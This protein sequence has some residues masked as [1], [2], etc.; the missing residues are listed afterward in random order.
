[1]THS[2]MQQSVPSPATPDLKRPPDP[3]GADRGRLLIVDDV[4]DNRIVL[5]RRFLRRGFEIAEANSGRT[6]LEMI[7]R[8]N[9]DVILLDVMMPD[10]DGLETLARIR[11][12]FSSA[13][14]PVIMVTAN[15]LSANVV[16]ALEAGANDYVAKPVDFS[17]A[18]AR[19]NVQVERKRANEALAQAYEALNQT[20][21]D[22]ERRVAER[23][24]QLS[25]INH[26]LQREIVSREQS[27]AKAQYLAYHDPLTGLGN[28]MMFREETQ[29]ALAVAGPSSEPLAVLF[30]D[31]DG[32]KLVNDTLGHSAGDFLLKALAVRLRDNLPEGVVIARLGGDEFGVLLSTMRTSEDAITLANQI[33]ELVNTP[34]RLEPNNL[35]VAASVGIAVSGGAGET[36]E[37][38][39]KCADLA[40]YQA[41]SDGREQL[42]PGTFRVFDPEMDVA[43]QAALRLKNEMRIALMNGGFHANYQPLVSI[44]TRQVTGFEALLR[45]THDERGVI[46][47]SV[48]IPIAESTGLIVQLGEWVLREACREAMTWPSNIK[49]A[50]N[51]SP[52]Q[53]QKGDLVAT[54]VRALGESRLPANRLELEITEAV[55]LDRSDRNVQILER[56]RALGVRISMDD[57]GTGFSSLSYLRNFPFD[58][59]KIDQSFVRNLSSDGRSLTIVSAITGLGQSFGMST[60]AE[61]VATEDQMDCLVLKGCTE[62]QGEF[63]SMPV[64]ASEVPELLKRINQA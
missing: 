12:T 33:V 61:G 17:V 14:L 42:G 6:A 45:W 29:R 18:L 37:N 47:P 43:A 39:L 13:D 44:E 53:F 48:F 54:V 51:L 30:I 16:E 62:A 22:L 41:K 35:V 10:I 40:M 55:L 57:F 56:L 34:V 24:S 8:E 28:R 38:L 52:V 15:N 50:V 63:Y 49:I 23:T 25:A 7:A 31:L 58:K 64:P 59:I 20:N 3:R 32:F 46:P 60:V 4:E 1:M 36:V 9:F 26:E 5:S 11:K 19:V 27:E 21:E 2:A